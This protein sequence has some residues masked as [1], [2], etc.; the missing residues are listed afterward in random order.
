M[1]VLW[2]PGILEELSVSLPRN[3]IIHAVKYLVS[4]RPNLLDGQVVGTFNQGPYTAVGLPIPS[5]HLKTHK[6]LIAGRISKAL[7]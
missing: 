4:Q 6:D 1:S 5:R 7:P 2:N 3:K